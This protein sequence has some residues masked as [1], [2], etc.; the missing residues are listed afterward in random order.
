MSIHFA[1][2]FRF[3]LSMIKHGGEVNSLKGW[4]HWKYEFIGRTNLTKICTRRKTQ[5]VEDIVF[6]SRK[7]PVLIQ[8]KRLSELARWRK[9]A[10]T[11]EKLRG[12]LLIFE[13]KIIETTWA[14]E[15]DQLAGHPDE[16]IQWGSVGSLF[17]PISQ[18]LVTE[19][20]STVYVSG[21]K[22]LIAVSQAEMIG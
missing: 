9:S 22:I 16:G 10:L 5:L 19:V 21:Q 12:N 2:R 3:F 1:S 8:F 13:F 17:Q 11:V 7:E 18:S 6:A 15:R 4:I 14:C 20:Q